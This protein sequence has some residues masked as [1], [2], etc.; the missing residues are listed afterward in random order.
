MKLRQTLLASA[1]LLVSLAIQAQTVSVTPLH[2]DVSLGDTF[3]VDLNATGFPNKIFGGG[4]NLAFDPSVLKLDHITIPASWEFATSTGTL[5]PVAGTVSD[6]FFNT[7]VAPVKGDFPTASVTF[8][9]IGVG[10]SAISLSASGSFPFGD[11]L[12]NPVAVTFVNGSATVT[13]V[14]EPGSMALLLAGLGCIGIVSRR[15]AI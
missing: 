4:Y 7:F 2:T 11:E 15:R 9:A 12:G 14:P 8:K 10:T 13:A 6:I 1:A 5:D 3:A